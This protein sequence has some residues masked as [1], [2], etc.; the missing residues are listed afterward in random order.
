MLDLTGYRLTFDEEFN[1]RSISLDGRG[2]TWADTRREWRYDANSDIGF[3]HS[4]FVDPSS[5][6]DP[7][8][9]ENGALAITAVPDRTA[10]GHPGSW[11]SGLITTQG[12]FSQTYGYFEM[13]AQLSGGIG[14]WDAFWLLPD[15]PAANTDNRP[16][17]QEID[18][19][20]HYG[21]NEGGVYGYVHTTDDGGAG[22]RQFYSYH[23]GLTT[24]YHTYGV[25]WNADT[26]DFYFDGIYMGSRATPSDMHGPM[27]ILA[28]LA[29][30]GVPDND[31][32][33][34]GV[35]LS[36][37]IDYIRA[38]S[39][40]SDAVAV[41]QDTPSA[42][43][44]RD[45]GLYGATAVRGTPVQEAPGKSLFGETVH[46][47]Q[48]VGA[49]VYVLFSGLLGRIPGLLEI[50]GWAHRLEHGTSL[51]SFAAELLASAEGQARFD[52]TD[53]GSFIQS[54][55]VSVLHRS[56]DPSGLAAW[57][58]SLASDATPAQVAIGFALSDEHLTR[59]GPIFEAGIF[60]PDK[61]TA[62][63]ARLY[64]AVLAR[65]PDALGLQ[66]WV[67]AVDAGAKMSNVAGAFIASAEYEVAATGFSDRQFVEM[68]YHSVLGRAADTAGLQA[69]T[70]AL[71]HGAG[72]TTI[73]ESFT[74]SLEFQGAYATA[75][76]TDY[77]SGLYQGVLGRAG[78]VSGL[79]SWT[80]AID[81]HTLTR[82]Q[83]A[84]AFVESAEFHDRFVAP[85]D[86]TFLNMLYEGAFGRT[87]D[88]DGLTYWT[89]AFAHGAS[90]ADVAA[91]FVQ[92]GEAQQHLLSVVEQGWLL[93]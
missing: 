49:Q 44:E 9:V 82:A 40:A 64:H 71:D 92:S 30:Q 1:R 47:A 91:I 13:R 50:E 93:S 77:V 20:E 22:E 56:A 17:W 23:G 25:N 62:D 69:W 37:H 52:A 14:A 18:I 28:D 89:A 4:S 87:A 15:T 45:P 57:T 19:V 65:V 61:A 42:P 51:T 58:A 68:L 76:S 41:A 26:I 84:H 39:N 29:T 85:S 11:E 80:A 66:A 5:G 86:A 67:G 12:N 6:Y 7:F 3:G 16:G 78:D 53:H 8:R 21:A 75:S 34:A 10:S 73:A 2:T 24:G 31:A 46:S 43:D 48:D 59:L 88:A 33:A 81:G 32:D 38:F 70:G 27:Y 54:L 35:P 90:R 63:V 55:Y 74:D 60:V 79:A 83:V 72:R 36:M